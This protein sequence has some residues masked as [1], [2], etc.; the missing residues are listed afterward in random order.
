MLGRLAKRHFSG[1]GGHS[2]SPL[3]GRYKAKI[4]PLLEY[5]SEAA[6]FK[7]RIVAEVEWLK[8]LARKAIMPLRAE[9]SL[10][11]FGGKAWLKASE[12]GRDLRGRGL[13]REDQ[14]GS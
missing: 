5:F 12:P 11:A 1:L 3:D 13:L 9:S 7:Y 8:H 10:E 14:G 4:S 2:L 6:F